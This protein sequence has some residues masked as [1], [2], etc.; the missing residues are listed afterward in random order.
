MWAESV[1]MFAVFPEADLH[2]SVNALSS[3]FWAEV[4]VVEVFSANTVVKVPL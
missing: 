2:A 4:S 3:A 1:Y